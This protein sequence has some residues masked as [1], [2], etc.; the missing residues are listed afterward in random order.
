MLGY[1]NRHLATRYT[2]QSDTFVTAFYGIYDPARRELVYAC[3]G[4]NP[5]RLKRCGDGTLASLDGV[6]GL[7]LGITQNE[8]YTERRQ[9]L[10]PGDQLVFYTDGVT[11]AR[12]PAGEMFGLDR[13]DAVL[14]GCPQVASELLDAVLK[15]LEQFTGGRRADD[16]R[17]LLVARIS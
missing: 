13:L 7:P 16:D 17:T 5:P 10:R 15:A 2:M 9:S 12:D 11:D 1:V 4:H 8:T 3:A 6:D 14:T